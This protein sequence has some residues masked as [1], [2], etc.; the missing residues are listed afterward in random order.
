MGF[1][2]SLKYMIGKIAS[3]GISRT[4]TDNSDL[5]FSVIGRMKCTPPGT[6]D[7]TLVDPDLI[8]GLVRIKSNFSL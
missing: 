1:H 6:T 4:F 2:V 5:E 3:V 7:S 8:F